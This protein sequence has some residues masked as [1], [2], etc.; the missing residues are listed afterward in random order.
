MKCK[1]RNSRT[2]VIQQSWVSAE[3]T[4]TQT[5]RGPDGRR[6]PG[7]FYSNGCR[8]MLSIVLLKVHP[9]KVPS[10]K[11]EHLPCRFQMFHFQGRKSL[12]WNMKEGIHF[13]WEK[14]FSVWFPIF[15][16]VWMRNRKRELNFKLVFWSGFQRKEILYKSLRRKCNKH[17]E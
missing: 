3:L 9:R 14:L 8:M 15:E 5:V 13:R 12:R 1:K 17:S 16:S 10:D 11:N 4:Q 6:A 2:P 7:L